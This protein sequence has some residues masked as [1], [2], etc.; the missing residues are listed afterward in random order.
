MK[1]RLAFV[2]TA[3]HDD[4]ACPPDV[5]FSRAR[6]RSMQSIKRMCFSSTEAARGGPAA[7]GG[8]ARVSR[9]AG[10]AVRYSPAPVPQLISHVTDRRA[11][12]LAAP[13][14]CG[15]PGKMPADAR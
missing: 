12:P 2:P 15:T 7:G 1:Q 4:H 11:P 14:V 13:R 6:C 5:P 10:R 3:Q 9:A 8:A